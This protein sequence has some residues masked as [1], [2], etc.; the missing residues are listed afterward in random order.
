MTSMTS[1]LG[2]HTVDHHMTRVDIPTGIAFDSFCDAFQ[3]AVP[4][5]DF[6]HIR[7]ITENGGTWQDIAAAVATNARNDMMRYATL[8]M[9]ALYATTDHRT[10]AVEYFVGNHVIAD[11]MATRL[12]QSTGPAPSSPAWACEKSTRSAACSTTKSQPC[13][14]AS[15][16]TPETLS[17]ATPTNEPTQR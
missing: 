3:Q 7:R 8:D 11:Q 16:S 9:T 15:E 12:S 2:P 5:F 6:A 13:C 17:V 10:K 4:A 14:G 1:T